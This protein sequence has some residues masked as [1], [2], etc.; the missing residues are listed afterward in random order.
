MT[1]T[2]GISGFYH[3]SAAA[4]VRDGE[5][6][7]AAQE[8]RFTRKKHDANFPSNAL[9]YCVKE[10]RV[11][12]S[13]IDFVTFYEKPFLKFER[14]LETYLAFAPKGFESFRMA[15]PLWLK[16]KLFQ[17]SLLVELLSAEAPDVDW[18]AKL[19]FTE[20]HE[21]HAA[22]AFYPSP[23]D[24]AAI[25]TFDGVGEWATSSIGVGRGH[26]VEMVR[27]LNFPN[28]LGLLYSAFT[29]YCGVEQAQ[30]VREVEL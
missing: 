26:E 18:S 25:L 9:R 16:E 14:L 29:Y 27:Q 11:A 12:W 5:I 19:R 21:S 7:A 20:H 3:D 4:L 2:L 28:S 10:A 30:R 24:A 6:V 1:I 8:E 23:F 17:K 22:S 13:D 15:I